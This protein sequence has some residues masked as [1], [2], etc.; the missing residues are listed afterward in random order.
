MEV[1][2]ENG[3]APFVHGVSAGERNDRGDGHR[4]QEFTT[5][6]H[7]LPPGEGEFVRQ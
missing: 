6:H 2:V 1:N 7:S 5:V 3:R 4:F